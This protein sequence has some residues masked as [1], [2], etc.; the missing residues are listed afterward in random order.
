M[1]QNLKRYQIAAGHAVHGASAAPAASNVAMSLALRRSRRGADQSLQWLQAGGAGDGRHDGVGALS[2]RR[3]SPRRAACRGARP[4]RPARPARAGRARRRQALTQWLRALPL[5]VARSA[6][7][8][9]TLP[10]EDKGRGANRCDRW[11]DL[12]EPRC[13]DH[14]GIDSMLRCC[15]ALQR[16]HRTHGK[17]RYVTPHDAVAKHLGAA[18]FPCGAGRHVQRQQVLLGARRWCDRCPAGPRA[19]AQLA[20]RAS[21]SAVGR[22]TVSLSQRSNSA[23]AGPERGSP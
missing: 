10:A 5:E 18:P 7:Q 1:L 3:G 14:S 20:R 16:R 17:G 19:V 13:M 4:R 11:R 21:R 2:P 15:G 9:T 8:P 6:V 22:A 12:R 23:A